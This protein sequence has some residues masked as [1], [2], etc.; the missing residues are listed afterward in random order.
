[1]LLLEH[2]TTRENCLP[3]MVERSVYVGSTLHVFVRLV[4][5][6]TIQSWVTNTGQADGHAA[7]TPVA[8]HLPSDALRVLR[9]GQPLDSDDEAAAAEPAGT[10]AA[11]A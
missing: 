7:G 6:A 1:M 4:D 9:P 10:V 5:G 2:G 11:G 3:G 8:V